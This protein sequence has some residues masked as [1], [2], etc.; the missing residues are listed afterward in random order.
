MLW[1]LINDTGRHFYNRSS[2]LKLRVVALLWFWPSYQVIC[3][4]IRLFSPTPSWHSTREEDEWHFRLAIEVV[5]ILSCLPPYYSCPLL[6]WWWWW[7]RW[8]WWLGWQKWWW[9]SLAYPPW[10]TLFALPFVFHS[11]KKVYYGRSANCNF[12]DYA[13]INL[14]L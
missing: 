13:P 1:E 4:V 14:D 8:R 11:S 6:K 5:L 3:N 2:K 9:L 7:W 10:N 12:K